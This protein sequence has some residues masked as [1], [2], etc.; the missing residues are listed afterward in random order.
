[1]QG[2]CWGSLICTTSMNKLGQMA[3]ENEDMLYYYNCEN[4]VPPICMVDNILALKECK[5]LSH[6]NSEIISF[7]ELKILNLVLQNVVKCTL[8]YQM[9]PVKT[10]KFILI[11]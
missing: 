11:P 3:Y 5:E 7:I 1:M 8:G 6:V 4:P 2:T 9:K 10:L